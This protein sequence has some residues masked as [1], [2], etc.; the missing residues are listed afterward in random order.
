MSGFASAMR[1]CG[2]FGIAALAAILSLIPSTGRAQAEPPEPKHSDAAL[3]QAQEE[4]Q[5]SGDRRSRRL[6]MERLDVASPD[7]RIVFTLLPNT[8]RLSFTVTMDGRTAIDPSP[9]QMEVDGFDLGAGLILGQVETYAID[10]SYPWHGAHATAVSRC[11]GARVA[12]TSD[13]GMI[14]FTL[15][16]RVFN[17]GVAYRHVVP[18]A[19]AE[20]RIP[21]ERSA[22]VLPS[23]STVWYHD[24]ENHYESAYDERDASAVPAGQWAAPP[25]TFELP[26]QSG[27]GSIAE[28]N[29]VGYS[30]MALEADGRRGFV[31]GLGH[32]QPL[33]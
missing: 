14:P 19:E 16:V 3:Q 1:T 24:L 27:Y 8:E 25:L 18:G 26:E 29:L 6:R 31:T 7:G 15:E 21:D 13:L 22:F 9:V 32:R 33:N 2:R 23:G 20:N 5:R 17:D 12:L 28:A 4:R 10:E 30:G 11:R